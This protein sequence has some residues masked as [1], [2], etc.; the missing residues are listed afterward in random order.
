MRADISSRSIARWELGRHIVTQALPYYTDTGEQFLLS[1]APSVVGS[2]GHDLSHTTV[3]TVRCV[4]YEE[5]CS[6]YHAEDIDTTMGNI[7]TTMG[8]IDTT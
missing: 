5:H 1:A 8:D 4:G 3:Y 2:P 7:H 6:W